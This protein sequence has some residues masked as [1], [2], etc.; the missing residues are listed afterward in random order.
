VR[1]RYSDFTLL[2]NLLCKFHPR[3]FI[4]PLPEKKIGGKRFK[5]NFIEKRMRI[6]QIFMNE[7]T[8]NE[9]FKTN[10]ALVS[11]LSMGD[12]NTFEKKMKELN[13]KSFNQNFEDIKTTE[14][15]ILEKLENGDQLTAEEMRAN[16]RRLLEQR[17]LQLEGQISTETEAVPLTDVQ[18]PTSSSE[19]VES[20]SEE[21]K[22]DSVLIGFARIFSGTIREG[23]TVYVLG[24]KYDP[25][26]PTKF[27]TQAKVDKL[28]LIM[29]KE[30]E[31]LTSVPAGNVFGIGGLEEAV[32]KNAT[33]SSLTECPSLVNVNMK[34]P[35]IVRVAV[36][37]YDPSDMPKLVEGLKLLNQ[38]DSC[39]EVLI[40]ETGE[41]VIV[42]AGELHLERCLKDLREKYAKIGLHASD[43]IVPYRE[44]LSNQPAINTN[45]FLEYSDDEDEENEEG[46]EE[47]ENEQAK[48][49]SKKNN[50]PIG[51]IIVSTS[52]NM[53]TIRIRAVPLPEKVTK[54]LVEQSETIK[55]IIEHYDNRKKNANTSNDE[56]LEEQKEIKDKNERQKFLDE[57]QKLFDESSD[58]VIDGNKQFWKDVVSKIWSFGS[59]RIGPNMLINNIPGYER[60]SWCAIGEK[61]EKESQEKISV[62]DFE[63]SINSG[64]Q[65]ATNSGPLCA[66]PMMGVC[67]ILESFDINVDPENT[68]ALSMSTL[69]GQVISTIKEGCNRAFL[70][71]SPRLSLATYSCE[72][73]ATA[74][75]LGKIYGV[76]SK[77]HARIYEE[78]LKEGT[79][80]FQIKSLLPVIESFGFADEIRKRTS[81]AASPQ[82]LF[83]GYIVLDQDPFWVPTTEEELE[84]LGEK[85]D[86]ENVAKKYMDSVR[87]RKGLF[88]DKKI[89]EHGEKQRTLKSK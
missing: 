26:D 14:E 84:D 86:K 71:W 66:E 47:G 13:S 27:C 39:V 9:T 78:D 21:K 72:I 58:N 67:F 85:A 40:Q 64:F 38:A 11:F 46:N 18:T 30:L 16:R 45:P 6:L 12:H 87:K 77:R 75:V 41:H 24:P 89:V 80:F 70:Q 65:I 61:T 73:Q 1:R 10:D 44:T 57:L 55:R 62:K 54:Y 52:K 83:H 5:P 51:T 49:K 43:P 53:C 32:L 48:V 15:A 42:T 25:M 68:D 63:G 50:L 17:K 76:L 23:Q 35:P 88:V 33:L 34:A 3:Y 37:P 59:K 36:E 69:S 4:P 19:N 81:G 2:R 7:I 20:N 31:A 79:Q 29:G 22:K 28:Y 56:A 82:L 74:E 8:C 60:T